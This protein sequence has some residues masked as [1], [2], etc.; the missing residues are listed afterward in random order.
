ML[1]AKSDS[2]TFSLP[3]WIHFLSFSCLIAVV[4]TSNTVLNRIGESRHSCLVPEFSGKAFSF[5]P[6]SFMLAVTS[7][8]VL[9][10]RCMRFRCLWLA[11]WRSL[12]L[13]TLKY[14]TAWHVWSLSHV[15]NYMNTIVFTFTVT[16][17]TVVNQHVLTT[18]S[19][20]VPHLI[21]EE[22]FFK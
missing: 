12:P 19:T 10:Q 8:Y 16:Y 4:S 1:S 11:G 17:S 22:Q 7:V 20:Q 15:I 14:N 21:P 6:L 13:L 18:G 9:I 5:S 2:F 3:I